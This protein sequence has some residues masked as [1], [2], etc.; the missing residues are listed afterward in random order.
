MRSQNQTV[1]DNLQRFVNTILFIK[2]KDLFQF[3]EIKFYPSEIHLLLF[4]KT[5]SNTNATSIAKGLGVTKGAVSQT[6]SRLE[7]KGVLLKT[8]DPYN[9]NELT[10]DLT[11]FGTEAFKHYQTMAASFDQKHIDYLETFSDEE[12]L[13]IKRFLTEV[14]SVF[15]ELG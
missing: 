6:L 2:K 4:M 1:L 8:K 10:L 11:P 5:Q 9:K 14:D 7:K 3:Q 12:K 15:K 13:V